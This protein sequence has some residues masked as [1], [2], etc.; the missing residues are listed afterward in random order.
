[1]G[2]RVNGFWDLRF[3]RFLIGLSIEISLEIILSI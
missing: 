3:G 2:F 1:M